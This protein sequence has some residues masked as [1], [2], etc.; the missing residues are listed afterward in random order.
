MTHNCEYLSFG[1]N[2]IP[3]LFL[4]HYRPLSSG[5]DPLSRSLLRFKMTRQPDLAAWT[6]CAAELLTAAKIPPDTIILRALHHD[7]TQAS[8][9]TALD[10]LCQTLAQ[11]LQSS[12]QPLLLRKNT[13]CRPLK[14]LSL[15]EKN[16]E[17]KDQ[18]TYNP[19]TTPPAILIVDD[20]YTSGATILAILQAILSPSQQNNT[21]NGIPGNL[22]SNIPG[23]FTDNNPG[24]LTRDIPA[25]TPG[26]PPD[27]IVF[28]LARTIHQPPSQIPTPQTIQSQNYLLRPDSTWIA[29]DHTATY[30]VSPHQ[31]GGEQPDLQNLISRIRTDTFYY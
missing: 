17:L 29:N 27:I 8:L 28:T 12:Y 22:I 13:P 23:N 15:A 6:D 14:D 2:N 1:W 26:R 7:E 24:N 9:T 18:Y 5:K 4:C 19:I 25:N 3:H 20:I 16:T 11:T 10:T 31:D 30:I 21:P